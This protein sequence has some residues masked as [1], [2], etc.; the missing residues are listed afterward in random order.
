M[1][2]DL[3]RSKRDTNPRM[4]QM[5]ADRFLGLVSR[6]GAKN[7]EGEGTRNHERHERHERGTPSSWGPIRR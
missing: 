2:M 4:T 6:E 1:A 5:D 3:S 7:A